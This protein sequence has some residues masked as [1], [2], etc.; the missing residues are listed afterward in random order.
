MHLPIRIIAFL[1]LIIAS[2]STTAAEP[3]LIS[4]TK[5]WDAGKHNAFT[6]LI[7]WHES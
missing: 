1:C 5:I 3:K 6:D 7:R 2:I 4:V